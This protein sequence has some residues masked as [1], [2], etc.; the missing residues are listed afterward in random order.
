VLL[1]DVVRLSLPTLSRASMHPRQHSYMLRQIVLIARNVVVD[2]IVLADAVWAIRRN[3]S[4]RALPEERVPP[5]RI[6]TLRNTP[7]CGISTVWSIRVWEL[8]VERAIEFR[9]NTLLSAFYYHPVPS[10]GLAGRV[11]R[12]SQ[13]EARSALFSVFDL[14]PALVP[15][16][17]SGR[18]VRR[19]PKRQS[20]VARPADPAP[21]GEILRPRRHRRSWREERAR[22]PTR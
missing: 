3:C 22:R 13:R 14:I 7:S 5:T 21:R 1:E 18:K 10:A 17:L 6:R 9:S 11:L 2:K 12:S 8:A 15:Q 16:V 19:R 4:I 20:A